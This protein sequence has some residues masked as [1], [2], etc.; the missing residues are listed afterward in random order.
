MTQTH[1]IDYYD[2]NQILYYEISYL[3]KFVNIPN[4][5]AKPSSNYDGLVARLSIATKMHKKIEDLGSIMVNARFNM[6]IKL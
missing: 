2:F 6:L 4:I 5:W 1:N 3:A